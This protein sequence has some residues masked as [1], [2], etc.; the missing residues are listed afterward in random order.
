MP[1]ILQPLVIV[2]TRTFAA[3]AA[4]LLLAATVRGALQDR[5]ALKD[6]FK[7]A[8]VMGTAVNGAVVSGTDAQ[9]RDIVVRHFASITP[10]NVMKAGSINPTR[11]VF[12]FGPAD[13]VVEFGEKHGMFIVGHTLVWHNQTPAGSSRTNRENRTRAPRRSNACAATSK[14]WRDATRG[15]C[16]PGM[17][18]TR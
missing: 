12:N 17:S 3:V 16:T 10:E 4:S 9:S 1:S 15:G 18:S 14:R 2:M 11:G 13:Q 5:P 8:F 6:V 7:D